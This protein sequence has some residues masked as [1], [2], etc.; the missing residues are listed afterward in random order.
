MT[1]IGYLRP[2]KAREATLEE[3]AARVRAYCDRQGWALAEL[4]TETR[5]WWR[6]GV[7]G[8][9]DLVRAVEAR[10]DVERVVIPAE[11][12]AELEAEAQETWAKV[13]AWCEGRGVQVVAVT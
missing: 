6:K 12:V 3:Q 10:T 9:A 7:V 8:L 5:S 4:V 13:R 1:A 11:A 2:G